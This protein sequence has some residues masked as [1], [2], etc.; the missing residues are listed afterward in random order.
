[1]IKVVTYLLEGPTNAILS[2]AVDREFV[3][4]AGFDQDIFQ[5][6]VSTGFI[7]G[8]FAGHTFIINSILLDS[9]YLYSGSED[10]LIRIWDVNTHESLKEI[11][12]KHRLH[13]NVL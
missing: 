6:D 10:R 2:I 11:E 7:S 9:V 1:M 8:R 3:Y 12:C 13:T 4:S 5:W